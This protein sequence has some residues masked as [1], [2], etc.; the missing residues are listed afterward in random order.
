LLAEAR[1][2]VPLNL[3]AVFLQIDLSK[4]GWEE[5]LPHPSFDMLLAFAVFHH[6]PGYELR[7]QVLRTARSLLSMQGRLIHSEWQFLNSPRLAARIQPWES[8]GLAPAQVDPGD[9]LLDWRQGGYGY[10]YVH[11]FDPEELQA[12][13]ASSGFKIL[14]TFYS[15]GESGN[16]SLY[17]NWELAFTPD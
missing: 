17:Q 9:Y 14:D 3:Q 11:H 2:A 8:I 12:L 16:L 10:R 4:P 13:A 5:N 1:A 15:D 6:L 7:R